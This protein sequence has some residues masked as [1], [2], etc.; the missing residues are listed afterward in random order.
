MVLIVDEESVRVISNVIGMYKLMENRIYLV[1]QITKPRAPNKRSAPIYFLSPTKSSIEKLI[2]DW[3]PSRKRRESLYA[4]E[5]FLYFTN[6]LS[7]ELFNMIKTC[8]PL[9]K[10]LKALSEV[11]MDFLVKQNRAFH[12]DMDPTEVFASIFRRTTAVS[13][14]ENVIADKLVTLCATLNEYPHIRFKENSKVG[15]KLAVLF[16]EKFTNFIASNKT[17]WYHGDPDHTERGRSTLLILSRSDDCLT[18][19]IHEFTYQAMVNDLLE[20][21]DDKI[22][23]QT[24]GE[25]GPVTK[26]VLLNEND[27]LWVELRGKHIADVIQTLSTRIREIVNSSTGMVH[28]RGKEGKTLS[29]NQMANALKALPE[30]KEVMSKL[31]QHMYIAHKCMDIF[32]KQGLLDLSELEQTLATGKN[33]EGRAPK[34]SEMVDLVEE[35][36][37]M[38]RDPVT[39]FRLLA[40]MIISQNGLKPADQGRLFAAAQ[41]RP[42]ES[43]ALQNLEQLGIPLIQAITAARTGFRGDRIVARKTVSDNSGSEYSSSRYA[44]DLKEVLQSMAE[45]QLSIDEY[46]SIFPLPEDAYATS[47]TGGGIASVRG[48]ASK[49]SKGRG[50]TVVSRGGSRQLVFIAGGICYSELRA[51]EELMADGG[52]EVIAGGTNF[53]SPGTFIESLASFKN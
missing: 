2:E 31:S 38:T 41:L 14:K 20:V 3:T 53:C 42:E 15:K 10:R 21:R 26:D 44:C 29:L 23:V 9:V 52:P 4:D 43:D 49:Y 1:E 32:K 6:S 50:N 37:K 33:D 5:V 46:P 7:D 30:Y 36:L 22:T 39:R 16:N 8:K 51:C 45:G 47:M 40:I 35:Q 34:V 19:L 25:D 12:F 28:S 27:E 13:E 18:P 11:N 17:W 48:T 24:Q